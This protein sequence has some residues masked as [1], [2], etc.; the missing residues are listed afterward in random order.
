MLATNDR[1]RVLCQIGNHL[2]C[3]WHHNKMI[4]GHLVLREC[5]SRHGGDDEV[6][7]V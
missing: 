6:L 1:S 2:R 3:Y 4:Q 7:R 5:E